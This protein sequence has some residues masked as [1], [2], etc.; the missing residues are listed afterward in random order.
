M[1][2]TIIFCDVECKVIER[3]QLTDEYMKENDLY[4]KN[5]IRFITPDGN[6]IDCAD[7]F[8]GGDC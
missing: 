7:T 2:N 8:E 1:K 3:Y 6:V 4:Y 5:R